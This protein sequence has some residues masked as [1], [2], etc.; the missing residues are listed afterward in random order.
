MEIGHRAEFD[1]F[2]GFA[3][4]YESRCDRMGIECCDVE[5]NVTCGFAKEK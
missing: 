3:Q 1:T 4:H 2:A 5:E